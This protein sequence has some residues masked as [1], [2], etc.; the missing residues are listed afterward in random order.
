MNYPDD[1]LIDSEY[2]IWTDKFKKSFA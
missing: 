2:S 1:F